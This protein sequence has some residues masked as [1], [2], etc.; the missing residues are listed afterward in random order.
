M[1]R[2]ARRAT[3]Y[4][5]GV[6]VLRLLRLLVAIPLL[7]IPAGFE[8]ESARERAAYGVVPTLDAR[9]AVRG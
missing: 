8:D 3:P 2:R 7:R 1:E 4:L 9:L 6:W 5:C